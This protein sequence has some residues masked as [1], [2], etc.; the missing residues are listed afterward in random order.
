MTSNDDEKATILVVDDIPAN[1]DILF[2]YLDKFGFEV[3]IAEDG[4]SALKR[5]R[6]IQPDLIL[7]D[8]M[9]PNMDGFE[10]CRQL[11][12]DEKTRDIPI[13]F[14]TALTETEDKVKG[15]EV[16][17]VDYVT[18]PFQQE[19]LLARITTHLTL[20]KLQKR[21]SEQ[22]HQLQEENI[23][24][25]RVQ[26]A[27]RESRERY[28]LLAE[29]S[30]DIIARLSPE[31]VYQY[32]SPA[33]RTLLGYK[34]EEM[35]GRTV[36]EFCHPE[37]LELLNAYDSGSQ[38]QD[39]RSIITY[40]VRRQDNSY[41]WLETTN[42]V[43]VGPKA[44][45]AKEIIA[46]ARDVTGRKEAEEALHRANQ[47]LQRLANLD[48]LTQVA[49]RRRFN[50]YLAQEWKRMCQA[51]L[52][53][54]LILCDIDYFKHYNDAYGH[55]A[56]DECLQQV[57]QTINSVVKRPGDLVAR[58]GGEEFAIILPNTNA[59]GVIHVAKSIQTDIQRLKIEHRQ[60]EIEEYIT[61]S[62]G[63][64]CVVPGQDSLPDTFV[65][66]VDK[67]LYEAKAQGRNRIIF[68]DME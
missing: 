23:R 55:Q 40:R 13:I 67:A 36:H 49:N 43:V 46:V 24:R 45:T 51:Q 58:Y 30:T 22:N 17:G 44:G 53:L 5:V 3:L 25:K 27:L 57:T 47:E 11:Q 31:G 54:S 65:A 37:D 26:D 42:K 68:K 52:P 41:I 59:N 61:L 38:K 14:I 10:T 7:L 50:Q 28:R 1:L 29:N 20:R 21:L 19:E 60:S 4:E 62:L 8:I 2:G 56:G 9:M 64:S 18:K 66:T 48:G 63:V 16:G 34:I 35:I 39:T 6:Y 15:F 33:C 32:V 12:H